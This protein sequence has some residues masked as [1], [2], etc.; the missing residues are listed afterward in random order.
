MKEFWGY[1][2]LVCLL[3]SIFSFICLVNGFKFGYGVMNQVILVSIPFGLLGTMI[4]G[5]LSPKTK[6]KRIVVWI[7]RGFTVYIFLFLII[8]TVLE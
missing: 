6:V 8:K 3:V 7:L 5:L 1:I 4:F 2:S